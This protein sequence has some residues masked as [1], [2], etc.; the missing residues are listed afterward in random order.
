MVMAP[1]LSGLVTQSVPDD[2][3]TPARIVKRHPRYS[4]MDGQR[5]DTTMESSAACQEWSIPGSPDDV[6]TV[7]VSGET[8]D[9]A[10]S[11]H[12]GC[13]VPHLG[14]KKGGSADDDRTGSDFILGCDRM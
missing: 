1:R 10:P 4:S 12:R 5:T 7:S 14:L 13:M 8:S 2:T 6:V 9:R 3:I 11:M